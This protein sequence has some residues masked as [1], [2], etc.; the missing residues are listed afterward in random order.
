MGCLQAQ[1]CVLT[2]PAWAVLMLQVVPLSSSTRSW[3]RSLRG[4]LR[5]VPGGGSHACNHGLPRSMQVPPTVRRLRLALG[6][7]W[8]A[9]P[10]TA[11][12]V[13]NAH[14]KAPGCGR[15][16]GVTDCTPVTRLLSMHCVV[17]PGGSCVPKVAAHAKLS[18]GNQNGLLGGASH[19]TDQ[20]PLPVRRPQWLHALHT[21]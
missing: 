2:T 1:V 8:P 20:V 12:F 6:R 14:R 4:P 9:R 15:A 13:A 5:M 19:S 11:D 21:M 18:M 3:S 17:V 10:S 16:A 7:G